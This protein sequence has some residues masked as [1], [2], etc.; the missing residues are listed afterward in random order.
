MCGRGTPDPGL[1]AVERDDDLAG[2]PAL[3]HAPERVN[4]LIRPE[5]PA[6]WLR[7]FLLDEDTHHLAH[8]RAGRGGAAQQQALE[9]HRYER[10]GFLERLQAQPAVRL[11]EVPLA[12][13]H[14][15]PELGDGL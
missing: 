13:L 12:Y 1:A 5:R 2:V 15:A 10:H 6:R 11:E 9:V 8:Q 14:E 7:E 4:D 3:G